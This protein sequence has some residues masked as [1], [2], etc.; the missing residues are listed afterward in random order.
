[1][2]A[3][4]TSVMPVELQTVDE[5]LE[6]L[7][8]F[9]C[10]V[11]DGSW[12][13]TTFRNTHMFVSHVER[14]GVVA[15]SGAR[16]AS[17][18]PPRV[19]ESRV[20]VRL[21][22]QP[23]MANTLGTMHGGAIATVI[24]TVSSF[25]VRLKRLC[26]T[27]AACAPHYGAGGRSMDHV[28]HVACADVP[29][30][31][32]DAYRRVDR[33][34]GEESKRRAHRVPPRYGRLRTDRPRRHAHRQDRYKRTHQDRRVAAACYQAVTQTSAALLP[35]ARAVHDAVARAA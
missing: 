5:A 34:R 7:E 10:A 30:S 26:A 1:M 6:A 4:S 22:V 32:A 8:A 15:R 31:G 35:P 17:E 13:G 9:V 28:W 23:H 19:R 12:N 21:Q 24:D 16:A 27:D 29:L 18:R 25:L 33:T 3:P 2:S 20:C 14:D 11:D